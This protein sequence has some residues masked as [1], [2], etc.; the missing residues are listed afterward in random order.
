[1]SKAMTVQEAGRKG[2]K[3]RALSLSAERRKEIARQGYAASPLSG[4]HKRCQV[5]GLPENKV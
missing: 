4:K 3:A 5:G 1:M 2:G